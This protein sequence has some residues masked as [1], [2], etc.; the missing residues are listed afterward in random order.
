MLSP[1]VL[2]EKIRMDDTGEDT[3]NNGLYTPWTTP[4][5]AAATTPAAAAAT[6]AAASSSSPAAAVL[7]SS[8]SAQD[9]VSTT[10]STTMSTTTATTTSS[11]TTTSSTTTSQTASSSSASLA[12]AFTSSSQA[13]SS[14]TPGPASQITPSATDSAL[15]ASLASALA[16][17]SNTGS[18]ATASSTSASASS[19]LAV[20][21]SNK[22]ASHS[23]FHATYLIPV[24]V[25]IPLAAV[26]L[27]CLNPRARRWLVPTCWRRKGHRATGSAFANEDED[28]LVPGRYAGSAGGEKDWDEKRGMT[29][30][31]AGAVAGWTGWVANSFRRGHGHG[32]D[33]GASLPFVSVAYATADDRSGLGHGRKPSAGLGGGNRGYAWGGDEDEGQFGQATGTSGGWLGTTTQRKGSRSYRRG[34]STA[35]S[36]QLFTNIFGGATGAPP[37][38]PSLYSTYMG[39]DG[40]DE[41]GRFVPEEEVVVDFD[42]Y[43][44]E[45]RVRD[46]ELAQRYLNG[47]LEDDEMET[48]KTDRA[49]KPSMFDYRAED[50]CDTPRR[51]QPTTHR[52][53]PPKPDAFVV[54]LPSAPGRIHQSPTKSAV[55]RAESNDHFTAPAKP[56]FARAPPVAGPRPPLPLPPRQGSSDP[57]ADPQPAGAMMASESMASLDGV[58]YAEETSSEV[59]AGA[60]VAGV[61]LRQYGARPI[62]AKRGEPVVPT[63]STSAPSPKRSGPRP[64]PSQPQLQPANLPPREVLRNPSRVKQVVSTLEA[65][66]AAAVP[67]APPS[68]QRSPR[69][70]PSPR[71]SGRFEPEAYFHA[72]PAPAPAHADLSSPA[73]SDATV[74]GPSSPSSLAYANSSPNQ[75]PVPPGT[76]PQRQRQPHSQAQSLPMQPQLAQSMSASDVEDDY[77]VYDDDEDGGTAIGE[78]LLNRAALS[79]ARSQNMS[80]PRRRP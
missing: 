79:R 30:A 69:R 80:V 47:N 63:I 5:Q 33:S 13:S 67:V 60:G 77:S 66:A 51:W 65:R 56:L 70:S 39:V 55:V 44:A 36:K 16:A 28:A 21:T 32:H 1:S 37:G 38:S 12:S 25:V 48:L 78:L 73:S 40:H 53:P 3:Y 15:S 22:V 74:R 35:G 68:P 58:A 76:Q 57:F 59:G 49:H 24:F 45:G 8:S 62:P 64:L 18:F 29:G 61:G 26:L 54:D 42:A 31:G 46:G 52:V 4:G 2:R 11:S 17:T 10:P 50:D 27:L 75:S 34:D 7:P 19:T 9:A 41:H 14:Q 23:S 20:T 71:W 72:Q 6:P 43:L